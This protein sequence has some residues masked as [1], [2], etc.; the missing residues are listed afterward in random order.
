MNPVVTKRSIVPRYAY[1]NTQFVEEALLV[2]GW[3][4]RELADAAGIAPETLSRAMRGRPMP[5]ALERRVM[6][7]VARIPERDRQ[8]VGYFG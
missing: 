5:R 8:P 6:K 4:V 1:L 7:A 3:T 2:G